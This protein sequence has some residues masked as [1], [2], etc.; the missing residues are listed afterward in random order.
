VTGV[1]FQLILAS[2]ALFFWFVPIVKILGKAGYSVWCS[3]IIVVQ[4]LNFIMFWD[5][6]FAQR[7]NLREQ[8][9]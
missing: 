5:F 6:A 4:L 2:A 8:D 3:V 7:P 9:R 1:Y